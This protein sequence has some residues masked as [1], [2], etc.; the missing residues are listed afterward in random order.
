MEHLGL[1]ELLEWLGRLATRGLLDE[2]VL[3]AILA[4]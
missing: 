1:L 3:Q 2:Q 4:L